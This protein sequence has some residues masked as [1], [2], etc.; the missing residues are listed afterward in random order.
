MFK[1]AGL[2]T[3][4]LVSVCLVVLVS[5]AV[6]ITYIT[7]N[8]SEMAKR[9][10]E[11]AAH[12]TALKYGGHI[13]AEL[14]RV[15]DVNRTVAHVFEGMKNSTNAPSRDDM[16]EILKQTLKRNPGIIAIDTCWEPNALDGRDDEFKNAAGHDKTG[17]F[18]PYWHRGNGPIEVEPLLN[19]DSEPWYTVPRDTG[20]EVLTDP[21]LYPVG[22][23]DVL[24]ATIVA[25]IKPQG[26][27]LG[28]TAIDLSL[29]IFAKM[30]EEVRPFGTGY[31]F[32]VAN[33]GYIVA[34]PAKEVAGKKLQDIVEPET[35]S[36]MMTAIKSGKI[37]S[38][39]RTAIAGKDASLQL[40]VPILVG[41]TDTPWSMGVSI[42]MDT[43]MENAKSLR[44][45]SIIIGLAAVIILFSV[46]FYI[47]HALVTRPLNRVIHGLKDIAQ[48]EGDLTL[49][50]PVN[51]KDEIGE[52][53]G[54]F[55]TFLE[56]LQRIIREL[57]GKSADVDSAST[58]LLAIAEELSGN[59]R[60]TTG[61]AS[62]VS[63][64]VEEMSAASLSAAAT[65]EQAAANINM[66]SASA[67]EM[68]STIRE[69]AKN[70]ETARSITENA[71]GQAG[72]TAGQMAELSTAATD[73]GN[74]TETISDISEQTNLLALNA[75]IEA[76]RAGEAG[77]G[78]A[79]VAGEIK[80]LASQTARATQ[81]IKNRITAIQGGAGNAVKG[82]GEISGII[83]EVN[84]IVAT[85]AT[86]V[87]EQSAA[88]N[89]IANNIAQASQGIQEV[90]ENI[91]QNSTSAA[92]ISQ[93]TAAVNR[94]A[95]KMSSS[96]SQVHENA[97]QMASLAARLKE[98]VDTFK[99]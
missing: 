74:V 64:A 1:N 28:M 53:S 36:A 18:V 62:T 57:A 78:F 80:D 22:G 68:A 73:I 13:Q 60:D 88:T 59:A 42:P 11:E 99:I 38:G 97:G 14:N 90:N 77:K 6:T 75:T 52:L 48:G 50:L 63:A 82:I 20:K 19:F 24:M 86:A 40:M 23:K 98:I 72:D 71:V 91:S 5:Y 27:F 3:K 93:E 84:T 21:Y 58:G 94:T 66:V 55:N 8:A 47:S 49:R 33:D 30:N 10:A 7:M 45:T 70:S 41:D 9:N 26:K 54:W 79:V 2:R 15:M 4:M 17:R 12:E 31:G 51:S 37:Y 61:K 65:M 16:N 29:E 25:P 85:I 87:E 76:A 83:E 32:I 56:K 35:A 39:T 95:D 46:V 89:E 92:G 44:N 67:D 34:H 43:I 69:I 96:S 81:D